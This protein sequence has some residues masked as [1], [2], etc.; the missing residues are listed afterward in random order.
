MKKKIVFCLLFLFMVVGA[1]A[2]SATKD[3]VIVKVVTG[4][5][6][7]IL[8][9][10]NTNNYLVNVEVH[11]T[12]RGESGYKAQVAVRANGSERYLVAQ[13][14]SAF[15]GIGEIIVTRSGP[16]PSQTQTSGPT[17]T[18][19]N[20]TGY[21]IEGV[22][23]RP[24]GT[25]AW[26]DDLNINKTIPNDRQQTVTITNVSSSNKY[27]IRVTD[28]DGDTYTKYEVTIRPNVRIVFTL[29]DIDN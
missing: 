19:V 6:N 5:R 13:N 1:F 26:G 9:I 10:T 20:N 2:Q 29:D 12:Y 7:R 17:I 21:M 22:H 27:D 16:A 23:I 14:S 3:G 15:I 4:S 18:I 28:N 25:R 11:F 24:T 8:E